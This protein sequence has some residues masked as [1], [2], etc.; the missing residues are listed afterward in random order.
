[1]AAGNFEGVKSWHMSYHPREWGLWCY[2][3]IFCWEGNMGWC[4]VGVVIRE[5]ID[6]SEYPCEYARALP[7]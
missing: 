3:E 7:V 2:L 1:M 4:G 6:L 5:S